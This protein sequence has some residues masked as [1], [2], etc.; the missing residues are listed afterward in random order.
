MSEDSPKYEVLYNQNTLLGIRQFDNKLESIYTI[1]MVPEKS[2][3]HSRCIGFYTRYSDALHF[4][5]K[6]GI[7]G[8]DE[9]GLFKY[10]VIEKVLEG[11]YAMSDEFEESWFEAD[12]KTMK[13][14]E[15]KK[16]EKFKSVINFGIG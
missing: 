13:W 16:P 10:L 1:T 15:I 11:I 8:L 2:G 7:N 3:E 6:F 12:F 5:E 4:I 9:G 14:K